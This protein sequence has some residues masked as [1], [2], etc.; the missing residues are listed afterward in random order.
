MGKPFVSIG[1]NVMIAP[2]ASGP[3]DMGVIIMIPQA[4]LSIAGQPVAVTGSQCLMTNS[5]TGVPYPLV[6]GNPGSSGVSV[7]GQQ[8]VRL[9]DSIP[10]PPG[11]LTIIGPPAGAFATDGNPP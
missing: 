4:C 1:C 5:I 6:I 9:G 8:A 7:A 11:V 2:G 10:T 3:P